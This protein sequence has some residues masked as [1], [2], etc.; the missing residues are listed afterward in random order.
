MFVSVKL[1]TT[2][3]T[4]F[5]KYQEPRAGRVIPARKEESMK[6]L[7][8][9][10]RIIEVYGTIGNFCKATGITPQA[11]TRI[12]SGVST[13]NPLAIIGWCHVLNIPETERDLFFTREV[14][15]IQLGDC[16]D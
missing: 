11:V 15:S 8:L 3:I 5:D 9:R 2:T 1:T 13:P 7:K 10:A 16:H 6:R 12:L 4:S 14:G